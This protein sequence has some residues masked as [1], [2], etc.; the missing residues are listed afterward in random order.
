MVKL[1][2]TA[3][4][5]VV[6]SGARQSGKSTLAEFVGEESRQFHTLDDFET[7]NTANRDP[8]VLIGGTAP[9]TLDEIQK[10]P[11]LL[12]GIKLEVDRNRQAGRFIL[13]GSTHLLLMEKVSESLAGRSS[14]LNL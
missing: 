9:V 6:L 5:V 10:A 12:T 8:Q 14:Y 13:T 11:K 4:P 7:L 3:M 2:L 1:H